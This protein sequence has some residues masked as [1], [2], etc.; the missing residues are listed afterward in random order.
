MTGLNTAGDEDLGRLWPAVNAS[1]LFPSRAEF[2]VFREQEPWRVRV[3]EA[4]RAVV[5]ERWREHLDILGIK[6]IWCTQRDLP[7]VLE[8]VRAVARTRGY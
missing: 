8:D 1:R 7:A 3:D 4:G 5:L 6:G 2:E